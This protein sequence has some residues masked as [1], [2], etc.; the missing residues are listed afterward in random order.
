MVAAERKTRGA[1]VVDFATFQVRGAR[2][3]RRQEVIL[4]LGQACPLCEDGPG[5]LELVRRGHHQRVECSRRLFH[6]APMVSVT[7]APAPPE[8]AVRWEAVIAA[9]LMRHWGFFHVRLVACGVGGWR[10]EEVECQSARLSPAVD[11]LSLVMRALQLA[12]LGAAG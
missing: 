8:N 12:G 11:L 7:W 10:V 4:S 6:V 5:E 9:A 3:E 1:R 2:D